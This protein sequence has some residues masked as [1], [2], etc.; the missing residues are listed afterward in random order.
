MT[1]QSDLPCS[2]DFQMLKAQ[3][4]WHHNSPGKARSHPS[5]QCPHFTIQGLQVAQRGETTRLR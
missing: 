1:S 3:G 4:R 5:A 2:E